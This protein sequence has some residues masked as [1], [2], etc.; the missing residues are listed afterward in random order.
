MRVL[1]LD[2]GREW[3]GGQTQLLNLLRHRTHDAQVIV[4]IDAPARDAIEA[5]GASTTAVNWSRPWVAAWQIRKACQAWRPDAVAAHTSHAHTAALLSGRPVVVHR[6]VDFVPSRISTPKYRLARGYI[7]VSEAVKRVLVRAGVA[8]QRV[9]VVHDGIEWPSPTGSRLLHRRTLGIPP[10]RRL[11]V[12]VG[13]LVPHKDHRTAIKALTCLAEP[14]HLYLVGEGAERATLGALATALGLGE[15]VHFVGHSPRP[16]EW[17]QAADVVVHPS[18]EEG[19]G[20]SILEALALN[21]AVVGT[22]AGGIPEVL[23]GHGRVVPV[24]SP[25]ALAAAWHQEALHPTVSDRQALAA[26]HCAAHMTRQ[27]EAAY[28]DLLAGGHPGPT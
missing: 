28:A 4:S 3:R 1:H 13:A 20:Q 12:C 26:A 14:W 2:S 18:R 15:R 23:R 17:M 21:C 25:Q 7:A 19:L 11:A 24:S 10:D 8:R 6:R 5:L 22:E 27:T 16:L 9:V